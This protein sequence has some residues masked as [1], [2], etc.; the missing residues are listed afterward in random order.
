VHNFST[1][2]PA[3]E[4]ADA[5]RLLRQRESLREVVESISSE[6]ALAPLLD[7]IVAHACALLEADAGSIGLY[8]E[9]AD[10]IETTA[11]VGLPAGEP[12]NRVRRGEGLGGEVLRTGGPVVLERY[13]RLARPVWPELGHYAVVGVPILW[14]GRLVGFFG[15]GARPPRR[16]D[17]QDVETLT[18][19]ARHAGIAIENA[20]R[21]EREQQRTERLALIARMGRI[22][23]AGLELP[24]L[25]QTAADTV[26]ELLGYPSVDIP[27]IDPRDPE[28]LVVSA[29][30]GLYKQHIAGED[31]LPIARGIM[32]AAARERRTLLVNDVARDPRYVRPTEAVP[33]VLGE[34]VLGVLNVESASPFDE[35]DAASLQIVADHLAVAIRNARLYESAQALAVLQERQRL[36][37]DLHDSVTQLLFSTSLM[38]QSLVPAWRKDPAEGERRAQRLVQL[39]R[40]ALAEMRAL[41]AGLRQ[42]EG[43]DSPAPPGALADAAG[44]P[45]ALERGLPQALR[46]YAAQICAAGPAVEFEMDGYLS[47]RPAREAALYRIAQEALNNAVKHAG[48]GHVLVRLAVE[49]GRVRLTVRDDGRGFRPRGDEDGAGRDPASAGG[50][51]G[52]L[53]MRDRAEEAGGVLLVTTRP[54]AGTAVEAVLPLEVTR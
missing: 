27:L 3:P 7:G 48:A 9:A 38:A 35:E 16:F 46:G 10:V 53:S 15:L 19:F 5:P 18:L 54:G 45:R 22:I 28:T 2:V 43:S 33:I 1:A 29:R 52:L 14:H 4:R 44:A 36:A 21:Y 47:Q 6:L 37:R 24:A 13:D 40:S 51:L 39:S 25:L 26:H 42:D 50:G 34:E 41:V 30:G 23:T 20:R 17:G 49:R 11:G 12:G 31:R 32:G 8:D